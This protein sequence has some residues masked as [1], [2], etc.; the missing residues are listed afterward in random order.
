M[1]YSPSVSEVAALQTL[2]LEERFHYAI[3]RMCECEEV[4]GLGDDNGWLIRDVDGRSVITIWPYRQMAMDFR[5]GEWADSV[6]LA[7]SLEH[8]ICTLLGQC[9]RAGITLEVSPAMSL[10]GYMIE[11]RQL[12]EILENMAETGSYFLE[13]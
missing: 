4:W 13:G 5:S 2:S 3:T 11:A 10:E 1:R 6:P 9:Q 7:V 12:Y 8:F